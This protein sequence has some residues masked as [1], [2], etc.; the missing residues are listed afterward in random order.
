MLPLNMKT[1]EIKNASLLNKS[2]VEFVEKMLHSNF[3]D[4]MF[5]ANPIKIGKIPCG[6]ELYS[7]NVCIKKGDDKYSYTMV[8]NK[9]F[10][11]DNKLVIGMSNSNYINDK[12]NI[13]KFF[14]PFAIKDNFITSSFMFE[15]KLDI[16]TGK[17][18]NITN[19]F[20]SIK[21]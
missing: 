18:N 6:I 4:V 12:I 10:F 5:I 13:N 1:V 11:V 19:V 16:Y 7:S 14:K 9:L 8:Q 2:Q 3:D 21:E 15:A 20:E 17:F